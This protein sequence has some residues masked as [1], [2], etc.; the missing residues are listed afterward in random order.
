MCD[1]LNFSLPDTVCKYL[2]N[3]FKSATGYLE[4]GS[5][6]STLLASKL[7]KRPIISIESNIEWYN[8]LKIQFKENPNVRLH[9]VDLLCKP[10]TWGH[11]SVECPDSRKRQYSQIVKT[12][13]LSNI[14]LILIDGRFRVACA[15]NIHSYISSDTDLLF[16]DFH[17]R[18]HQYR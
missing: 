14:N 15:L 6:G 7:V 11:P 13:D 4:F 9:L 12:L 16:D 18:L 8:R 17:D 10:K 2:E 1:N 3:K 5:G